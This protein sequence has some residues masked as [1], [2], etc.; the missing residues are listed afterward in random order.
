MGETFD[1]EEVR[2]I[3]G[4]EVTDGYILKVKSLRFYQHS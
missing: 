2:Y 1:E 4:R 3:K